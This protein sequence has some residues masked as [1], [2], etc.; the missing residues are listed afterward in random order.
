[1]KFAYSF[2][3]V[4]HKTSSKLVYP[5]Q[6]HTTKFKRCLTVDFSFCNRSP[7]T[8]ILNM[9]VGWRL[10]KNFAAENFMRRKTINTLFAG[11][12]GFRRRNI[13]DKFF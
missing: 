6:T 10:Q 9:C 11:T 13:L 8:L 12:G 1:M 2:I 4:R 5:G 3:H 7:A